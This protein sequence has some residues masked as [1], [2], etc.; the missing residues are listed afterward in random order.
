MKQTPN[1]FCLYVILLFSLSPCSIHAQGKD[2]GKDTSFIAF[3][4]ATE[5]LICFNFSVS[6]KLF[7][8]LL[9]TLKSEHPLYFKTV[10]AKAICAQQ[11]TPPTRS[12]LDE[13][14]VLFKQVA[15]QCQ[16]ERIVIRSIIN[17]GRVAEL[18]DY[19]GDEIDLDKA[20]SYYQQVI[21]RWPNTDEANEAM[22]WIAGTYIQV[23]DDAVATE[24]GIKLLEQWLS[25]RPSNP[26]ASTMWG[27]LHTHI[28]SKLRIYPSHCPVMFVQTNW[29]YLL[30]PKRA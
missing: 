21:D 18:R 30:I 19:P 29:D 10:L 5:E 8:R 25:Q 11:I 26:F 15:E 14:C 3:R 24:Q 2:T 22:L 1:I 6:Y 16:D 13:A 23:L 7:E 4:D 28:N 27:L 12:N 17:L 20:R 9:L